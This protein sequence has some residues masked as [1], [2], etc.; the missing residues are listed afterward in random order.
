MANFDHSGY[1]LTENVHLPQRHPRVV[2]FEAVALDL[3]LLHGLRHAGVGGFECGIGDFAC[4][5]GDF[6]CG[7]IKGAGELVVGDMVKV[8][9]DGRDF[10][11][12]MWGV[13]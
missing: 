3:L 10:M 9:D 6:Q 7:L 11:M 1:G 5:I 13:A 4:G 12:L 8:E 2:V